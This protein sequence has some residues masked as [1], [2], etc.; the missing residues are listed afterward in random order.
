MPST[1]AH[2]VGRG[3]LTVP[4][5]GQAPEWRTWDINLNQHQQLA[6]EYD[7]AETTAWYTSSQV[8]LASPL[9][10]PTPH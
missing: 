4:G 2:T 9:P 10:L 5:I 1:M 7:L 3:A 8:A 6:A